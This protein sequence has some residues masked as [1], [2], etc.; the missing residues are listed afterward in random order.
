MNDV[1]GAANAHLSV[2]PAGRVVVSWSAGPGQP[3]VLVVEMDARAAREL[4]EQLFRAGAT[5]D[6]LRPGTE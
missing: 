4:G 6:S 1:E 2:T 3:P 5:A